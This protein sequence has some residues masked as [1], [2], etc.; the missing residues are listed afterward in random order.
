VH[1]VSVGIYLY[2]S[3]RTRMSAMGHRNLL[4]DDMLSR[5]NLLYDM[6]V[7]LILIWLLIIG[8]ALAIAEA[9]MTI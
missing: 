1:T 8:M 5:K 7:V 6:T 9:L 4:Q 3:T 2:F